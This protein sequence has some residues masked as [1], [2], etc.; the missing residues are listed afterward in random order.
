MDDRRAQEQGRTVT[1]WLIRN[2]FDPVRLRFALRTA[3]ACW[4]AVV[5]AWS[6]GL[7]HPQWSGMSVWAASQ[8]LR[9]QLL[10]KGFFR[11]AGTVSGTVVGVVLVLVM[12]VH[13]VLLVAG[14]ALWVGACTWIG[15]LQRGLVAYGTVL[16]GYSAAM[17]ALLDTAHPDKVLHLGADRL[18]TVLTGVLVATAAGYLFA[19][20]AD[21]ADLRDRIRRLLADVLRDLGAPSAEGGGVHLSRLA[22][23]EEALDPHAAGSL[24]S[25]REVQLARNVL[26]A[27]VPLMIRQQEPDPALARPLQRG[28]EALERGDTSAAADLLRRA[29]PSGL[30][31]MLSELA[32]ALAA[33]TA[34]P[35]PGAPRRLPR[36]TAPSIL[37]R[38]RIGARE[39]GL[40]ALG[41]IL[42][43][44]TIWI[45]TGWPSGAFMLLGLSVMISL[46]STFENPAI[47]MRHI[48]AGQVI[49]VVGAMA[50]R[51]IVWPHATG[52]AQLIGM[53][54]PF[55]L[56]GPPLVAHRRTVI[57]GTDYSMVFL[58]L[59]QPHFPLTG[60]AAQSAT[61]ALAVLAGPLTA[62]A[63]YLL[64]FPTDLQRR[65]RNLLA[66]M[67]RDIAA[68]ARDPRAL[69]QR[70][71]W[72]A[73]L[74]H[75]VLRLVRLSDRLA[76]AE[77]RA[78]A[79]GRAILLLAQAALRCHA[80]RDAVGTAPGTDRAARLVL[81]RMAQAGTGVETG[82]GRLASALR[83]LA[84]RTAGTD[85]QMLLITAG[86]VADL[87]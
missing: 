47:T 73:R 26:L 24:R 34:R 76:R 49:G 56:L 11:F 7:E 40:R 58:L 46:F 69:T 22:A 41:A 2:G 39:A 38:D 42:L 72:E 5:I 43:F 75:R 59:S 87:D 32:A 16:A 21:D 25:R 6:L 65:Q 70:A 86:A 35:S 77:G 44:G 57:A 66:M 45:M 4:L 10:E 80:L 31:P 84:S 9:G 1:D 61:M 55:I 33:W 28:A 54:L 74:Y 18:A 71:L 51:W 19:R 68:M 53:M 30:R 17:V 8:P 83:H 13:P 64:V 3:L 63:G 60:S 27:A 82:A 67:W 85:R 23:V 81:A 14:L 36:W 29:A 15:N 37:Y 52:E 50:C 78:Q 48:F 62:W 20:R 79:T 12:Q